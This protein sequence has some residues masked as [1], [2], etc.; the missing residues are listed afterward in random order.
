M[1][2][3]IR[4]VLV[5]TT[6]AGNIGACAR[7]MKNMGLSELALVKPAKFPHPA[8]IARASGAD[9]ILNQATIHSTLTEAIA[10]C[11][12]VLAT[13]ARH[14]AIAWPTLTPEQAAPV[15]LAQAQH[16]PVALVFGRESSGLTNEELALSHY[17][18]HIP[19]VDEFSSLNLAMA[20]TLCA[21]A[22]RSAS[23]ANVLDPL[24]KTELA[25]IEDVER[26]YQHLENT[27]Q[28]LEF[29]RPNN[30]ETMMLKLRRLF[31]RARLEVKEVNILRGIL[32][33]MDR[34]LEK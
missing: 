12:L 3:S 5:E 4:I 17:H 16:S 29:I 7:V 18:L 24:P 21:Y 28:A 1:L 30:R 14:R 11:E 23:L 22:L 19:T 25:N 20:V 33:N 34:Y 13:S 31:N 27:L 10:G 6:H 15:I 8:A 2:S 26:F 9:D 32:A